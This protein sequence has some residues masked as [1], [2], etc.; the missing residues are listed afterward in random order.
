MKRNKLFV[1][2]SVIVVLGMLL[3]ACKPYQG[4]LVVQIAPNQTAFLLPAQ[5]DTSDQVKFDSVSYLEEKQ[6]AAKVVEISYREHKTG[7]AYWDID[8]I[9]NQILVIVDRNVESR[10][11]TYSDSTGGGNQAIPLES[12]ES[13]GFY[14]GVEINALIEEADAAKFLYYWGGA[15]TTSDATMTGVQLTVGL[16]DVLD[17]FVRTWVAGELYSEFKQ[18][19]LDQCQIE[20]SNI[21]D[22]VED[23]AVENFE[24][25]GITIVSLGGMEGL[26]YDDDAV[27]ADINEKFNAASVATAQAITNQKNI[28]MAGAEATMTVLEAEAESEAIRMTGEQLAQYP[29]VVN[30]ILAERSTGEVPQVLVM[31][32]DDGTTTMPFPFWFYYPTEL[33]GENPEPVATTTPTPLAV[34]TPN[35]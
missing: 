32:S 2:L 21:F 4:T 5:G 29:S 12:L 34:D 8:F 33:D 9:P 1:L 14:H 23:R 7:R 13:I 25:Y 31:N 30:K 18:Y 10:Q 17:T 19:T 20:A 16:D 6:V 27:Q 35:P 24:Q 11:W 28:E 15:G 3:S 26:V 22:R